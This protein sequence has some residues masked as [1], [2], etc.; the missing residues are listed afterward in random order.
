MALD[1][2]FKP[3]IP[4]MSYRAAWRIADGVAFSSDAA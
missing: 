4:Q 1:H 2:R 3:D